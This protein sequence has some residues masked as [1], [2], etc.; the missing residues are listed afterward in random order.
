MAEFRIK[1]IH[2]SE[3]VHVK[4]NVDDSKTISFGKAVKRILRKKIA[5]SR[6]NLKYRERFIQRLKLNILNN[7]KRALSLCPRKIGFENFRLSVDWAL[8]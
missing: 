8:K 6:F 2:A 4:L 3:V 7:A 1:K 5:I